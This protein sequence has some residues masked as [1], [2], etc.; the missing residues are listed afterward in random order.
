MDGSVRRLSKVFAGQAAT[1]EHQRLHAGAAVLLRLGTGLGPEHPA[2]SSAAEKCDG[3]APA[4]AL[5][6]KRTAFEHAG[7]RAGVSV[8]GKPCDGSSR[9]SALSDLVRDVWRRIYA[10]SRIR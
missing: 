1:K 2:R 3:L 4:R 6:R 8:Q 9:S 5:S 7:F 10:S